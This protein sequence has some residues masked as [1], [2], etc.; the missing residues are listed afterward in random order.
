MSRYW[1]DR[2]VSFTCFLSRDDFIPLRSPKPPR[3]FFAPWRVL[4]LR[5]GRAPARYEAWRSPGRNGTNGTT[6][7]LGGIGTMSNCLSSWRGR[8]PRP[9]ASHRG[10][11]VRS[12]NLRPS[13]AMLSA[14]SARALSPQQNL[15]P[16]PPH[17]RVAPRAKFSLTRNSFFCIFSSRQSEFLS[18]RLNIFNPRKASSYQPY[19]SHAKASSYQ[20]TFTFYFILIC[21]DAGNS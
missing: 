15:P 6:S 1:V 3:G 10:G 14:R 13:R 7:P 12:S 2:R 11:S 16:V 18:T 20:K 19:S 9:P 8:G 5:G 4:R 17:W 21:H